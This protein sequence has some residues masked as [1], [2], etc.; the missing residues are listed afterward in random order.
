MG[1]QQSYENYINGKYNQNDKAILKKAGILVKKQY[2][3]G[4]VL[5]MIKNRKFNNCIPKVCEWCNKKTLVIHE[6]H[7]PIEKRMGGTETV[8]ICPTCHAEYHLLIYGNYELKEG[9]N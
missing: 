1:K 4:E 6:H 7:F 2:S 8:K 5:E 3:Q 9:I